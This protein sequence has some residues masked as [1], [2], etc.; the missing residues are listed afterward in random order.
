MLVGMLLVFVG[1]LTVGFSIFGLT[2]EPFSPHVWLQISHQ[3]Y[4]ILFGVG[5]LL[6]GIRMIRKKKD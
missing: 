4:V 5:F 2:N 1:V 6:I 3:H